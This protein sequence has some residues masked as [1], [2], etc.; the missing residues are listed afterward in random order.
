MV[1]SKGAGVKR[2][3]S[4]LKQA[5]AHPLAK[6]SAIVFAGTMV[7]NVGAYLYHLVVGRILGPAQYGE[8]A[9]LLSLS[10]ILNVFAIMLQ[11]VVTRFVAHH[12]AKG[13]YGDI[14]KLIVQLS[15]F[16]I[17]IGGLLVVALV[18]AAPVIAT[19][20]HIKDTIVVYFI[21][22]G[23]VISMISI[24]LAS[25]LQGLQRFTA[26]MIIAN[27]MSV[28][29]LVAGALAA[30]F[31]VT[32]TIGAGLGAGIIA[33]LLTLIPLHAIL[34]TNQKSSGVSVLALF[35]TSLA[36]FLTILGISV[37][38]SQDV[39]L[40]KH[41]LPE[42][43]SGWYGALSTM[44]K[45]IFFA[46][47]SIMYVLLPVVTER[48]AKGKH[49][50]S[51]VY[52]SIGIVAALSGVIT[53][54][55][56]LLP[57]FALRLL[58]GSAF[59]AAAPYLGIFGIFSSLYTIA[60]TIVTALMGLGKTSAWLILIGAA[61]LQDVLLFVFHQS[62]TMVVWTNITVTA[63]LVAALLLYYRHALSEH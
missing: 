51:I 6:G 8:L 30:G 29:R 33:L 4:R 63:V 14:R 31:G 23:V 24:V 5:A 18:F 61:L 57:T 47:S 37:M 38:N 46:S 62:I 52:G 15:M 17:A 35:S 56:F 60:Y 20:L 9:A 13:E 3:I 36:T 21:F 10:Y 48:S 11:T 40:V 39:V 41:F 32:V 27:M 25:V 59:I 7:A 44:G 55:F 43:A 34:T 53:L 16:L 2:I 42:I 22:I 26:G 50:Q 1:A 58:Y 45:I 28:L 12:A 19:F 54:G 49:T